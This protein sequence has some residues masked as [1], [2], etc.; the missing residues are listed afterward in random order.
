MN[1]STVI[2]DMDGLLI[3]SEPLWFEAA[4]DAF[5]KYNILI[6]PDEYVTTTGL[7][8]KEFLQY[9]FRYFELDL[10]HVDVMENEIINLVI[11]KVSTKAVLMD[12]V[13]HAIHL[14]KNMGMKIGL[15]SSS[16]QR[17][18]DAMIERTGFNDVFSVTTSAEH[19][20]FGKPHPQVFIECARQLDSDPLQCICFED[21]FNGM[22]AAKAAKM[23]CIVVPHP[24]QFTQDRYMAADVKLKSLIDLHPEHLK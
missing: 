21:S 24:E 23:K 11:E 22:I 7:R 8:T 6:R 14:V 4:N 17:L 13:E 9:W 16:P 15:A 20:Q 5:K 2:F 19:L 1:I 18:I 10:A 3:D 12:G